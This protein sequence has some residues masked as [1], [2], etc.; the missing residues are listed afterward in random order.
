MTRETKTAWYTR[1]YYDVRTSFPFGCANGVLVC[2]V[3]D[4]D[5]ITPGVELGGV[6]VIGLV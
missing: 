1:V 4:V 3:E 5:S 2:L 6:N